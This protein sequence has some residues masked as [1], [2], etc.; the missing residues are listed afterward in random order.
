MQQCRD[1]LLPQP[2]RK[3]K[4]LLLGLGLMQKGSKKDIVNRLVPAQ[5]YLQLQP[6]ER[7]AVRENSSQAWRDW[8]QL[9]IPKNAPKRGLEVCL[10][11]LERKSQVSAATDS[12]F[13]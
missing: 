12:R 5:V 2:A 1:R 9:A 13:L 10:S 8:A 3:L 6:Q 11:T 7:K 4:P